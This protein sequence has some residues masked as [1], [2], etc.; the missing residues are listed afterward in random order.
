MALACS[1]S[2]LF[3]ASALEAC[4]DVVE[5]VADAEVVVALAV[6]VVAVVKDVGATDIVVFEASENNTILIGLTNRYCN[7]IKCSD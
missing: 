1:V 7:C 3:E 2:L 5:D 4:E 6:V